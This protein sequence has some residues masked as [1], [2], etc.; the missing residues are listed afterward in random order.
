MNTLDEIE[1]DITTVDQLG[2]PVAAEL[3]LAL[4]DRSLLRLYGDS[5]P[6]IGTYFYDQTRTGAF[7]TEATRVGF[8]SYSCIHCTRSPFRFRCRCTRR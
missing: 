3:S 7:S 4:V 1:V 5:L 2:R 6:N 8:I